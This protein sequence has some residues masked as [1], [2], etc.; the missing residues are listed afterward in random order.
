[1]PET[2]F[3]QARRAVLTYITTTGMWRPELGTLTTLGTGFEDEQNWRVIAG[4]REAL[5]G[6]DLDH[7]IM[8]WPAFLVDKQ[9]GKVTTLVVIAN[10]DRLDAMK[11]YGHATSR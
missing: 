3:E 5:N 4:A 10:F 7:Q 2:T 11:P 9:T 8:D 1:M 6:G